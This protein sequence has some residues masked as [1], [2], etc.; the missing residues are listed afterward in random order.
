MLY[1]KKEIY[2]SLIQRDLGSIPV[3]LFLNIINMQKH[4]N[5]YVL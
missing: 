4:K 5:G 3:R 2:K 1:S